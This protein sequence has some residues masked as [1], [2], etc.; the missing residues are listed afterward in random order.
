MQQVFPAAAAESDFSIWQ[1]ESGNT[2]VVVKGPGSQV[3]M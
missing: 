1:V 2:V 3:R